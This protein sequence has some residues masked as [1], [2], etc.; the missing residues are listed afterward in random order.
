MVWGKISYFIEEIVFELLPRRWKRLQ[1]RKWTDL[2]KIMDF[3]LCIVGNWCWFG[4][5]GSDVTLCVRACLV[6]SDSL[7]PHGLSPC[8]L[9]HLWGF[10]SRN[11][12]VSCNFL[13]QG[14][15]LIKGS[16][17]SLLHLLHWKAD[18][19]PLWHL[20]SCCVILDPA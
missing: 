20:R 17:T 8:R 2:G 6:M 15:F 5:L 16:N 7:W 4:T 12:G 3:I 1:G 18:S 19:L 13:L 14:I 10:P 11:T 9:L